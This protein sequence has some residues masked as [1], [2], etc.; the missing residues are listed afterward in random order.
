MGAVYTS[1]TSLER[2]SQYF[3]EYEQ[4]HA[5]WGIIILDATSCITPKIQHMTEQNRFGHL[6]IDSQSSRQFGMCGAADAKWR[7]EAQYGLQTYG[8]RYPEHQLM[9]SGTKCQ[10][11]HS[12]FNAYCANVQRTG[13]GQP[14]PREDFTSTFVESKNWNIPV[15]YTMITHP[16]LSALLQSAPLE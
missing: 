1:S 7:R 4:K 14:P 15:V 8:D 13:V 5:C 3:L 2:E 6:D 16:L 11:R 10:I 9:I 12:L